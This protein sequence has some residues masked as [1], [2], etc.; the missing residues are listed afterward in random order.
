MENKG[1]DMSYDSA[2]MGDEG[3]NVNYRAA[4]GDQITD[5]PQVLC[6]GVSLSL[7]L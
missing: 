6:I 3:R 2:E 5:Q 1:R 7:S 4:A